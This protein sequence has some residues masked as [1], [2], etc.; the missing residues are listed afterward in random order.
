MEEELLAYR[1][2]AEADLE[3]IQLGMAIDIINHEFNQTV[4]SIRRNIRRLKAWA[5]ANPDLG[6]LYR[7]LRTAF[8]HLD[9][10]LTLFAPLQRRLYRKAIPITGREIAD[11]LRDLFGER[12]RQENVQLEA[13]PAF[14]KEQVVS[15]PSIFY[16]VFINLVDNALFWLRNTPEPRRIRLDAD[17]DAFLIS[18]TG[19]GVADRDS[20]VIFEP[21]FTRKPG[22]RGLGLYISRNVLSREG[23][24]LEVLSADA[25]R[26]ATFRIAQVE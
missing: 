22:G 15:F 10:Y 18:D 2:R 4:D 6:R 5:D 9:G 19:P 1:E 23:Y 16:P 20:D 25:G 17:S 3:L 12:L 14:L 26:G 24:R 21:G 7:D 8:E 13:T 11:Y